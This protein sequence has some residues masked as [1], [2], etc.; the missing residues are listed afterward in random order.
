MQRASGNGVGSKAHGGGTMQRIHPAGFDLIL[1]SH[2]RRYPQLQLQD[3]YKLVHQASLGSEHAVRDPERARRR[4]EEE[5]EHPGGGPEEP[6]PDPISPDGR[7]VRI[8]LRPYLAAGHDPALL[9][10]SFLRTANE[11][12]GSEALL[13]LYWQS[14][15]SFARTD[16]LAVPPSEVTAYGRHMKSGG[17]PSVHHTKLYESQYRPAY[18]VVARDF[19]P[20]L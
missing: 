16:L 10:K 6:L 3:L 1:A 12:R 5:V 17:Y 18:R 11:Y 15:R 19:L 14:V 13:E 7:I 2:L 4:L 8:H 9:L 20:E